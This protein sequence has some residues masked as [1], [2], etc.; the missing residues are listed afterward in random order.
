VRPLTNL[1]HRIAGNRFSYGADASDRSV[2]TAQSKICR[3]MMCIAFMTSS[4]QYMLPLNDAT[5]IVPVAFLLAAGVVG[6]VRACMKKNLGKSILAVAIVV[7]PILIAIVHSIFAGGVTSD[8]VLYGAIIIATLLAC[9]FVVEELGLA[10][11]LVAYYWA[12]AVSCVVVVSFSASALLRSLSGERLAAGTFHPNL[13]GFEFASFALVLFWRRGVRPAYISLTLAI[14][15]AMIVYLSRSRGSI[16]AL[17]A[18]I[19]TYV[20]LAIFNKHKVARRDLIISLS[21]MLIVVVCVPL[22][23][24]RIDKYVQNVSD[25]LALQN[26]ERGVGSGMSGRIPEWQ[27]TYADM[28]TNTFIMG[29]GARITSDRDIDNGFIVVTYEMGVLT[30]IA[31]S[32]LYVRA[33]W[34][35]SRAALYSTSKAT[36]HLGIFTAS[37]IMLFLVNNIVCRYYFAI[38]NSFSL[39]AMFF[40]V[41]GREAYRAD[42]SANEIKGHRHKGYAF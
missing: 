24:T 1:N 39:L 36:K 28:S 8:P 13:L 41:S 12:S 5:R 3:A 23:I 9:S 6:F 34:R 25:D 31:L 17:L 19:A 7:F 16:I 29:E 22:A 42:A 37:L 14:V 38:G 10:G 26:R 27:Q 33:F 21:A 15:S 18:G 20:I 32:F 40:L 4:L 30:A 11:V 35:A 2:Q